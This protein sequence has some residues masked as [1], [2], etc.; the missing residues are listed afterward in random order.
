MAGGEIFSSSLAADAVGR[1]MSPLGADTAP[2]YPGS[3]SLSAFEVYWDHG[4]KAYKMFEPQ[5]CVPG[6]APLCRPTQKLDFGRTYYCHVKYYPGTDVVDCV[7]NDNA[8]GPG[9]DTSITEDEAA[10]VKGIDPVETHVKVVKVPPEVLSGPGDLEM[11]Q[12]H[13]GA[14]VV[15]GGGGGGG[16]GVDGVSADFM[17]KKGDDGSPV[18]EKSK[19]KDGNDV[20]V[21]VKTDVIEIKGWHEDD[22]ADGSTLAE[23][24]G[25]PVKTGSASQDVIVRD[26]SK[27]GT[28][29][30]YRLGEVDKDALVT[31]DP[32][33]VVS[34]GDGSVPESTLS[35]KG[36]KVV[37]DAY[38][39]VEY[40]KA[41]NCPGEGE[42]GH[43]DCRFT[44][45]I[46]VPDGRGDVTVQGTDGRSATGSVLRIASDSNTNLTCTVS[47]GQNNEVVLTLGV[48]YM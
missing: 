34:I 15:G 31:G 41:G 33:R 26:G 3:A 29:K 13:V 16:P 12:Y 4:D 48:R 11:H 6:A 47:R 42:E 22:P 1:S 23:L 25:L 9:G 21:P 5:V 8:K 40:A 10:R 46:V 44:I 27:G 20:D 14:V 37:Q 32:C 17:Q 35:G 18:T 24:M 45:P 43:D 7:V 19:D 38:V 30:Y 28:L 36:L 39:E 2:P